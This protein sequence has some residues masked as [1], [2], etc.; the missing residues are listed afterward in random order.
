MADFVGV[1]GA[2]TG[3]FAHNPTICNAHPEEFRLGG[4]RAAERLRALPQPALS[5]Q[6]A[7]ILHNHTDYEWL[8]ARLLRGH[9]Y[10]EGIAFIQGFYGCL[11][12]AFDHA[13]GMES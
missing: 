8:D 11:D 2:M 9:T 7:K 1:A 5:T 3:R 13:K 12:E 6:I 10:E 4:V